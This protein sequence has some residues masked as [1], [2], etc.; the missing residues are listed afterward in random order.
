M[1]SKG[2]IVVI[3]FPFSDLSNAKKRPVVVIAERDQDVLVCAITS[4]P[5]SDG[6]AL[7]GY[8]EGSLAYPSK[9]KYWQVF[10]FSKNLIISKAAKLTLKDHK[11]LVKKIS[12]F[13]AV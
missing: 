7:S 5:E 9:I 11:E 6:L 13:I 8:R 1:Y 3:S 10:T 4:N 2:D 12:E